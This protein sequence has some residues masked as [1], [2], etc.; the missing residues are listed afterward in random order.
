[1]GIAASPFVTTT[2][3]IC[4][5]FSGDLGRQIRHLGTFLPKCRTV[6]LR[7]DA[8]ASSYMCQGT[9]YEHALKPT[10]LGHS[11]CGL[12]RPKG[13]LPG[14]ISPQPL[15]ILY[16]GVDMTWIPRSVWHRS[17]MIRPGTLL[18]ATFEVSIRE[19]TSDW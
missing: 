1:M 7:N 19:V 18:P 17:R 2:C 14:L 16:L 13:E 9:P 11:K 15:Y 3:T 4:A 5:G 12:G 8:G 10:P 6:T